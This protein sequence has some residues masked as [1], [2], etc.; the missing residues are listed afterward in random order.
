MS[1]DSMSTTA[2]TSSPRANS[3]AQRAY[4]PRTEWRGMRE[5]ILRVWD[6]LQAW[7]LGL[8][9]HPGAWRLLSH[10][11]ICLK[12]QRS[13]SMTRIPVTGYSLELSRFH[14]PSLLP[15]RPRRLDTGHIALPQST[16]QRA[17][18]TTCSVLPNPR[19]IPAVL[20]VKC[21][22]C[23]QID[24]EMQPESWRVTVACLP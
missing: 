8:E 1:G 13:S 22:T 9:L 14:S 20:F 19:G 6:A 7:E 10:G 12:A 17:C 15:I 5:D 4:S 3:K 24:H 21:T 18:V 23:S 2:Q 16:G 11:G